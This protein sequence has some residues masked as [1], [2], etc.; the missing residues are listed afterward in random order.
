VTKSF[1][2]I[3]SVFSAPG[4]DGDFSWM[5]RQAEH[6]KTLFIFN[7]NEEQFRAFVKGERSGITAG[8]GNAGIRPLRGLKPPRAAGVPTGSRGGGYSRLDESTKKVIDDS[9]S[10]IQELL[11]SGDYERMVFSKDKSSPTLGTGIFLVAEDVKKYIYDSLM[12]M[13]PT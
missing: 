2:V 11:N 6:E 4:C 10:V 9:L 8:G 13:K 1:E 7:D 5:S 3:A 12:A